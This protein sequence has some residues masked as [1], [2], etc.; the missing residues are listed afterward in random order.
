MFSW[1]STSL[2]IGCEHPIQGT[3]VIKL[4]PATSSLSVPWLW[5]HD[6]QT[7]QRYLLM[8]WLNMP[9]PG[10]ALAHGFSLY[11]F[12]T[13]LVESLH[14][15]YQ[16]WLSG[17]LHGMLSLLHW[18]YGYNGSLSLLNASLGCFY[19]FASDG[20]LKIFLVT[21]LFPMSQFCI[22]YSIPSSQRTSF[23]TNTLTISL[24]KKVN[25]NFM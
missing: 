5:P 24:Q 22:T 23:L 3:G 10:K 8:T 11:I 25:S 15:L 16:V 21:Q 19:M 14:W 2:Q 7:C 20:S 18:G 13:C 17:P 9:P 6:A 12:P 1:T 4:H